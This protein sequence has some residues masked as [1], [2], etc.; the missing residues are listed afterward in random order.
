MPEQCR[1]ALSARQEVL[2]AY[3]APYPSPFLPQTTVSDKPPLWSQ[4]F[5]HSPELGGYC[6][7]ASGSCSHNFFFLPL[8]RNQR[9]LEAQGSAEATQGQEVQ[10]TPHFFRG[11]GFVTATCWGAWATHTNYPVR[12]LLPGSGS[13]RETSLGA[14]SHHCHPSP[15]TPGLGSLPELALALNEARLISGPQTP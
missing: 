4:G 3:P 7:G 1:N 9:K 8:R 5:L 15:F 12:E 14:F 2:T 6:P 13:V 11:G 10:S